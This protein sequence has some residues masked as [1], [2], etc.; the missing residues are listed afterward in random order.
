MK[1]CHV[2]KGERQ[3]QRMG[4]NGGE[5]RW[6]VKSC[7]PLLIFS[8]LLSSQALITLSELNYMNYGYLMIVD[9]SL[10]GFPLPFLIQTLFIPSTPITILSI[11]LLLICP[12][13]FNCISCILY[14]MD[15][16]LILL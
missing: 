10:F 14:S 13:Y 9:Q 5:R 2:S 12:N 6:G 1:D 11:G 4:K 8:S 3:W 7:V 15:A 16:T